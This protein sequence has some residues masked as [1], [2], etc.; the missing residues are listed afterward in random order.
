MH[1]Q[2][3]PRWRDTPLGESG[4]TIGSHGCLLTAIANACNIAHREERH[5][6]E[7]LNE[8]LIERSG[9]S[10][11]GLIIWSRVEEALDC[12]CHT[13]YTGEIEGGHYIVNFLANGVGH[14]TNLVSRADDYYTVFDVWDGQIKSI[15]AKEIRRI[16]RIGF[17]G[18]R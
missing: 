2:R 12:T 15:P 10:R 4:V 8:L 14:F 6:P 17:R 3:D 5:T 9:L 18:A 16:V 1:T 13:H 7:T 11:R